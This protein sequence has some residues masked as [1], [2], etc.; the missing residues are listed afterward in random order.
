MPS[1]DKDL[2]TDLFVD[3][4]RL[5]DQVIAIA[6]GNW[7]KIS[8]KPSN[9][10]TILYQG[11]YPMDQKL[12]TTFQAIFYS[13]HCLQHNRGITTQDRVTTINN[14]LQLYVFLFL[15]WSV[16]MKVCIRLCLCNYF[17][18][19]L[20]NPSNFWVQYLSHIFLIYFEVF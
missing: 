3:Q 17:W 7:T 1:V 14:Q 10:C 2:S 9:I 15:H 18:E 16:G 11:N 12:G 8:K 19:I 6:I 4:S 13:A 20:E 5:R